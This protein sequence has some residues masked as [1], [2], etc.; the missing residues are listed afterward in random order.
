MP[1]II[2]LVLSGGDSGGKT[3]ALHYVAKNLRKHRIDWGYEK[4]INDDNR[5]YNVCKKHPHLEKFP[6]IKNGRKISFEEKLQEV[7][8]TVYHYI[9]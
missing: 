7:L 8:R 9:Q 1:R 3:K 2:K 4:I 5:T 6:N